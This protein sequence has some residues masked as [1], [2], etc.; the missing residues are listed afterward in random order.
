MSFYP[1]YPCSI[2]DSL[3]NF[4]FLILC[5][6]DPSLLLPLPFFHSPHHFNLPFYPPSPLPYQSM[7]PSTPESLPGPDSRNMGIATPSEKYTYVQL[8][9]QIRYSY[10]VIYGVYFYYFLLFPFF[11]CMYYSIICFA[12]FLLH[13]LQLLLPHIL[14]LFSFLI[15]SLFQ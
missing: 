9:R 12:S 15:F 4:H 3:T 10:S 7:G 1:S 8:Y 6:N 5:L 14:F 2:T 11:F 13:C